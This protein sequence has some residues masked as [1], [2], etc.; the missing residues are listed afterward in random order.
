M[1]RCLSFTLYCLLFLGFLH[2]DPGIGSPDPPNAPNRV[3]VF[4]LT[5]D[6]TPPLSSAL[7]RWFAL[8][9]KKTPSLIILKIDTP[10]GLS[11]SMRAIIK[12]ILASSV[13]VIGYVAP[14]G[15]RA[16]SA[17]TY[18]LYACPLAAM[19]E[20]TNV[21]SATPVQIGGGVPFFPGPARKKG[22]PSPPPP[23]AEERKILND[24]VAFIRSLAEMNGRNQSWAIRAVVSADNLSAQTALKM[25]VVDFLAPDMHTL[26]HVLDGRSVRV[27]GRTITLH[28]EPATLRVFHQTWKDRLLEVLAQPE[29][30]YL[31][32]LLG[33]AGIAF[34]FS[35]PGF[36]VPGVAGALS[37]I[38]ALYAFTILPVNM[39]GLLLLL[40]GVSLMI[41]E[42]LIGAFGGLAVA[43][44]LSFFLG[45]LLFFQAPPGE[46]APPFHT[47]I[48][49]ILLF[50]VL[51][52]MF[53][54]GI[55][56]MALRARLRP[57]IT[58]APAMG[59]E[60]GTA[61]ESF[62]KIGRVK[63]HSEI[64]WASSPVP[65]KEGERVVVYGISGLTLK[66]R[67]VSEEES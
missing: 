23:D 67:P 5:G 63:L 56:G 42:V 49:V 4:P 29:L 19:A 10:G 30:A 21:G 26:L 11:S 46:G 12:D 34:E 18:I 52:S 47:P 14:S 48:G 58:G 36:V 66:V 64:W 7:H 53:F 1:G 41:A 54:L 55:L 37:F 15:A 6:V 57:V 2:P 44:I 33:V 8:A 35:H 45:S 61:L 24:A 3:W 13:P 38:L 59:G 65:V 20:G 22:T 50:T 28:L 31:L 16:A 60:T 39:T 25:H 17:G 9:E 40:L 62:G 51:F 32:F 43:G 27:K